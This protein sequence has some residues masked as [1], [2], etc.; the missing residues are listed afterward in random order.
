MRPPPPCSPTGSLWREKLHLQSLWFIH[1]FI[2]VRVPNKEPS[3]E[4]GRKYLVTVHRAPRGWKAYIQWGAAW[5][6]KGIVF[7]T[8]VSTPVPCSLQHDTFHL[9]LGRP[10]PPL[11]SMCHSNLHQGIPSTTFTASHVTQVRV[12]YE[13]MIPRG[14]EGLELWE[15][16]Y[17]CTCV[18]FI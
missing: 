11:A 8:A 17:L 13:S 10:E 6:P 16:L 1:S 18:L 2:S 9:G 12:E 5:F 15:A 14:N 7:N 4:K 3:H